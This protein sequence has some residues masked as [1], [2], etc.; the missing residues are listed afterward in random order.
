MDR[1]MEI[2]MKEIGVLKDF[3]SIAWVLLSIG[4]QF[5]SNIGVDMIKKEEFIEEGIR[6][7]KRFLENPE[8][9]FVDIEISKAIECIY[10]FKII[11][12]HKMG[13][14]VKR[15]LIK[16][17]TASVYQHLGKVL[18]FKNEEALNITNLGKEDL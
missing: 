6:N 11:Q 16:D 2:R 18:L 12:D 14:I 1:G 7:F 9:I 17:T 15:Y 13:R 5:K 4:F 8:Q 10:Y 3:N